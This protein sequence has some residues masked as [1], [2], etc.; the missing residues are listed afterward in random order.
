MMVGT[1]TIGTRKIPKKNIAPGAA[2]PSMSR[3]KKHLR[4][5]FPSIK[6]NFTMSANG[7]AINIKVRTRIHKT[8]L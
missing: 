2:S 4:Q 7:V 5:S 6:L 8:I 1:R 3:S